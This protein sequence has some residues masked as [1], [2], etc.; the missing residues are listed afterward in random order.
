MQR[1]LIILSVLVSF[2]ASAQQSLI[3]RDTTDSS[4]V[5]D[6]SKTRRWDVA[7]DVISRYIWRGQ[8]WGGNYLTAQ[9]SF[10]YAISER[11]SSGVWATTNFQKASFEN[12][13]LSS[14]GY[15]ELDLGI[16]YKLT[17]FLSVQVWDYYWPAFQQVEDVDKSYFNYGPDGVKS[18]DASVIA[19]FSEG[20]LL[21]FDATIS[22]LIA[23]NDYRYNADGEHPKQ[24]YTTYVEAGYTFPDVMEMVSAKAFRNID[25]RTA[26][27]AVLNNQAAYYTY[28]DYDHPSFVNLAIAATREFEIGGNITMPFTINYTYNAARS[29]TEI[30]G[31][32]FV[33][34]G[35]SFWY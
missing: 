15:Q 19:D 17:D 3:L 29:N 6:T 20:Y 5:T 24:N 25:L 7:V 18:V 13:G 16:T 30:Y 23:G 26:V 9:P 4:A 27:G 21:S 35:L 10:N 33:T 34:A 32:N 2:T 11:L 8:S 22:T 12:D 1:Y 31:K 14:R 28:A